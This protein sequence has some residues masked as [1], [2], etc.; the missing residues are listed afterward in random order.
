[1]TDD[2][3]AVSAEPHAASQPAGPSAEPSPW[4]APLLRVRGLLI[5]GAIAAWVY[6]FMATG[7][8]TVCPSD[9]SGASTT[10]CVQYTL[11][12]SWLVVLAM[13]IV[14]LTGI[15]RAARQ[16]DRAAVMRTLDRTGTI[17]IATAL[18]SAVIALIWFWSM[19][20]QQALDHGGM[21]LMPFPFGAVTIS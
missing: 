5:S 16:P 4:A 19:P 17:I 15:G 2:T 7:G 13:V 18:C 1:M 9:T 6:S 10:Q 12:P 8:R 3:S 11:G 20:A 21:L 14:L